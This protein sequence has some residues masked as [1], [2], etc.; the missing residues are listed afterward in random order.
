MMMKNL[1]PFLI[2]LL[3]GQFFFSCRSG[4]YFQFTGTNPEAHN[5]VK[6]K[7]APVAAVAPAAVPGA[8]VSPVAPPAPVL[9]PEPVLEAHAPVLAPAAGNRHLIPAAPVPAVP[10]LAPAPPAPAV[11]ATPDLAQVREQLASMTKAEKKAL[12]KELRQSILREQADDS[13]ILLIIL[14]I[15]IPPLAVGLKEGIGSRFWISLLL[16]LLFFVP[17]VIYALLVVT[18]TI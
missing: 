14:A 10:R 6:A 18:D 16:T 5:K 11:A 12:K 13:Q 4:E 1:V 9:A 3:V 8:V 17:G 7:P 2:L 15:L